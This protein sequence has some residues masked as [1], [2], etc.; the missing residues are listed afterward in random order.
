L[1]TSVLQQ[2][3]FVCC[4]DR[5]KGYVENGLSSNVCGVHH[6]HRSKIT[7]FFVVYST[8]ISVILK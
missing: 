6:L 8:R 1:V 5:Y 2:G 4:V 3:Q 7:V